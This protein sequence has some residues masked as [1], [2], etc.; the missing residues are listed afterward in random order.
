[1]SLHCFHGFLGSRSDFS[2]FSNATIHD[3]Y[4]LCEKSKDDTLGLLDVE[5]PAG[6]ILVGY[7]FGGRLA[8]QLFLKNPSKYKQC[9]VISS[10]CGLKDKAAKMQRVLFDQ[11][12]ADKLRELEEDEFLKGWNSQALFSY[13][14]PI[15]Q[16]PIK[17][18]NILARFFTEYGL[19]TQDYLIDDLIQYKDKL[20]FIYGEKDQKYLEYAQSNIKAMGFKTDI[21]PN[22]GHRVLQKASGDVLKI[23]RQYV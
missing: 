7:S 4:Q 23:V 5:I 22:V 3:L 14:N 13:D 6:S 8:M 11:K 9:I 17:D 10:H 18:K 21:L 16:F 20:H 12:C 1:M 2:Q 15:T 19:S